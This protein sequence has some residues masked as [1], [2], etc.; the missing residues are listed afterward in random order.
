MRLHA[1][2]PPGGPGG[3]SPSRASAP[4]PRPGTGP[5]SR[6]SKRV[7]GTTLLAFPVRKISSAAAKSATVSVP[8]TTSTPSSRRS[9]DHPRPGDAGEEGAVRR[10]R[11]HHAV[12]HEEGVGRGGLG[13]VALLVQRQRVVEAAGARLAHHARVVGVVAGRLGLAER[14]V[15]RRTAEGRDGQRE[16][17]RLAHG[18]LLQAD[19]EHGRFGQRVDDRG[20]ALAGP[21]HRPQVERALRAHPPDAVA[22][23][24]LDRLRLHAG[25]E[26]HGRRRAEQ[27]RAVQVEVGGHALEGARPVEDQRSLPGAVVGRAHDRHVARVP[28]PVEPGENAAPERHRAL[29]VM[30]FCVRSAAARTPADRRREYPRAPGP[31]QA[32]PAAPSASPPPAGCRGCAT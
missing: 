25:V 3:R 8:S 22:H 12:A 13:D 19:G 29:P 1:L 26:A 14:R 7:T 28:A 24:R 32:A 31:G 4:A 9:A 6:S 18:Q 30:W 5:S 27:A 11:H 15:G 23:Q 2:R 17:P 10:R 16:R 20:R 21:H